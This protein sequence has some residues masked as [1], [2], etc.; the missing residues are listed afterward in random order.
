MTDVGRCPLTAVRLRGSGL[1]V[2]PRT[3][4][5]CVRYGGRSSRAE[6][7]QLER[8]RVVGCGITEYDRHAQSGKF[9]F[10]AGNSVYHVTD[11]DN[12]VRRVSCATVSVSLCRVQSVY[13]CCC[14]GLA[15]A[16]T[17]RR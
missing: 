7:L 11:D 1:A 16:V 12:R 4:P 6:L 8:K 2:T 17:L 10:T 14:E 15:I 5:Q 13:Q 9:I 3:G